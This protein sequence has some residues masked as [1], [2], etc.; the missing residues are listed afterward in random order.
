MK[1]YNLTLIINNKVENTI[2]DVEPI[3]GH[4]LM[5]NGKEYKLNKVVLINSVSDSVREIVYYTCVCED[6]SNNDKRIGVTQV[7]IFSDADYIRLEKQVNDFLYENRHKYEILS[8]DYN[9]FACVV[10]YKQRKK[11]GIDQSINLE[12]IAMLDELT[13]K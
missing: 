6:I 5:Y 4:I 8:V 3:E 7:K 1:V 2:L 12:N 9:Y 13:T 11:R 10:K